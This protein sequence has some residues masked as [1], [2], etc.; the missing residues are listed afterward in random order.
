MKAAGVIP[1]FRRGVELRT[2]VAAVL[3]R[4]RSVGGIFIT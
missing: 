1:L 2:V 4:E 3:I